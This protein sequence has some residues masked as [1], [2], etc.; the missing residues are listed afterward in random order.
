MPELPEVETVRRV[1]EHRLSDATINRVD[2]RCAGLRNPFQRGFASMLKGSRFEGFGRRGKYLL[3]QMS[4]TQTWIVHLGMTGMF[5]VVDRQ[6]AG[7]PASQRLYEGRHDHVVVKLEDGRCLIYQDPRK[8]GSMEIVPTSELHHHAAVG[9]LGPE[10][11]DPTFDDQVLASQLAGRRCSIKAALMNQRIVA[12]IGN[13]YAAESLFLARISPRRMASSL[14]GIHGGPGKRCTRL[15]AALADVLGR[16][17]AAG[18][19]TLRDFLSPDGIS[20]SFPQSFR[21]YDR[22]GLVCR[23]RHCAG[24]IQ[25]YVQDGRSTF[26]C[27]KCQR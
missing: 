23:R 22:E 10:P 25:R 5:T 9:R 21:V 18:G 8:F 1:L 27:P 16:A 11:I 7:R 26:V 4:R 14:V 24:I 20:G 12:G 15:A 19:S 13:I 3:L 6:V 2:V 17:I